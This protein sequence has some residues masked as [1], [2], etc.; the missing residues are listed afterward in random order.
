MAKFKLSKQSFVPPVP[1]LVRL[2]RQVILIMP[3]RIILCSVY[4]AIN[5]PAHRDIRDT[6]LTV[7]F[8]ERRPVYTAH[9][10]V[11]STGGSYELAAG[12]QHQTSSESKI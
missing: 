7:Q 9:F 2:E 3:Y 1:V 6:P 8:T 5:Q 11:W 4:F 10:R 12:R